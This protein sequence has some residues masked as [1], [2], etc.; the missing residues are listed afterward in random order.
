MAFGS[1]GP[2]DDVDAWCT[3]CRMT[4]NHRVIAVVGS[5]IQRVQCLTCGGDHKYHPPKG[6]KEKTPGAK[7]VRV[8]SGEKFR[9]TAATKPSPERSYGEWKTFMKDF[10]EGAAPRPYRISEDFSVGEFIEHA[11][12]GTGRVVDIVGAEKIEV[13]F[14][15]GRKVLIFN[16]KV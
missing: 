4:L 5:T 12:F 13:I 8:S 14:E 9:K 16:K 1:R 2:G 11:T 10:P 3:R 7:H 15:N 6:D